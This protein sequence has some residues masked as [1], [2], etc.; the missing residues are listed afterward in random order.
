MTDLELHK[1]FKITMDKEDIV[2]VPSFT[3]IE[4]D[5][6]L[7][8]AQ[9]A[10]VSRKF[11]GNNAIRQGVEQSQKRNDDFRG[12]ITFTMYNPDDFDKDVYGDMVVSLFDYPSD[13]M[14]GIGDSASIIVDGGSK[15]V[16]TIE[17]RV[18]YLD[19]QI[20]N[21]LSE[22]NI[23]NGACKPL[24]LQLDN[25]IMIYT[26]RDASLDEYKLFYIKRPD[27]IDHS[28]NVNHDYFS[29]EVWD[30]I[31]MVASRMA[32]ANTSDG[33]YSAYAQESQL[34]E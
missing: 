12:L 11:T 13:Y 32:L 1:A 19:R 2:T 22:H 14:F 7:N 28:L 17:T 33:R 24:R 18:E 6:W 15:I 16:D 9:N 30:E 29:D 10:V 34:A 27:K 25:M 31:V 21:R 4:I 20:N 5:H 26:H 3:P 8:A 23:H